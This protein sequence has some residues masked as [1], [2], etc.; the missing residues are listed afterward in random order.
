MGLGPPNAIEG[1]ELYII[2]LPPAPSREGRGEKVPSPLCGEGLGEER[3]PPPF[4][5]EG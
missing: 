2:P 5:G 1:L 3:F 4:A